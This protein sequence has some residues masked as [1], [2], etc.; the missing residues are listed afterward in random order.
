MYDKE[1]PVSQPDAS[2]D[3]SENIRSRGSRIGILL[4]TV[5][6]FC[7]LAVFLPKLCLH[8]RSTSRRAAFAVEQMTNVCPQTA[9]IIPT[10]TG[11][12]EELEIEFAT[13]E[14][15]SHVYESLGGAIRIP[16]VLLG[17]GWLTN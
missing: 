14:F 8:A 6:A 12:L 1:L 7:C 17:C 5:L 4:R 11:L 2:R 13:D 10:A 16:Y 3:V 9:P 15:R